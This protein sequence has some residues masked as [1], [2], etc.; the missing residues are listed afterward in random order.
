MK[1]WEANASAP[2]HFDNDYKINKLL[3]VQ[4]DET[5]KGLLKERLQNAKVL[6]III[7]K[8][9]QNLYKY[10]RFEIDYALKNYI[11]IIAVHIQAHDKQNEIYFPMLK[12]R[13][14]AYI[15][16][17]LKALNDTLIQPPKLQIGLKKNTFGSM[18]TGDTQY[19]NAS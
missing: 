1:D 8:S 18:H 17:S 6:V 14:T 16:F 15:P 13:L 19:D 10:V 12:N 5:V 2:F 9:T 3:G 4:S 11:P 7:G